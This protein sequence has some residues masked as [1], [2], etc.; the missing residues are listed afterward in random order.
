MTSTPFGVNGRPQGKCARA[1]TDASL[2]G[3]M[4][5]ATSQLVQLA[6]NDRHT[7]G[8][9]PPPRQAVVNKTEG[10]EKCASP[11]R[12]EF[13]MRGCCTVVE[14]PVV[15]PA[16]AFIAMVGHVVARIATTHLNAYSLTN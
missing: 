4:I 2:W 11:F 8:P 7:I 5:A 14:E 9:T 13:E 1:E 6:N 10:W 16:A 3:S 15:E 12:E